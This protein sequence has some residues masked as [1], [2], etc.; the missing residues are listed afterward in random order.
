[1]NKPTQ[2]IK[3][4]RY[5]NGPVLLFVFLI[6]SLLQEFPSYAVLSQPEISALLVQGNEMFHQANTYEAADPERAKELYL[7]SIMRFEKIIKEG[8]IQNGELYYNIGNAY[9]RMS[10]LG[11]AI[12]NYRRAYQFLP[13]DPNLR[14][15]LSYAQKLRKDT[16][17]ETQKTKIFKTL[18]FWHYD[19]STALQI[20]LFSVS[21]VL[22]WAMAALRIYFRKPFFRWG[23]IV[24]AAVA[25]LLASSLLVECYTLRTLRPGVI[26]D[27]EI[28]A[29]KGNS[30]TYEPSFTE[31]L[32]AGLEFNLVEDRGNWYF[33][34]LPDSRRC[35]VPKE[36]TALVR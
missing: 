30:E 6:F 34:E 23:G 2:K 4:W 12:L 20:L 29:R 35:W 28:T 13:N 3:F 27:A 1:M 15:N 36:S 17:E 22:A 31:P 9:F 16:V 14:Q 26:I 24:S 32:H 18:F 5:L 7:K 19:L 33:I 21:F 25:L 8:S 11:R 10:D